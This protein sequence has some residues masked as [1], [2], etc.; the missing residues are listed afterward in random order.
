[1]RCTITV[2]RFCSTIAQQGCK[3]PHPGS[4]QGQSGWGCE[5]LGLE[6]GVPADSRGLELGDIKCLFQSKPFYHSVI[7]NSNTEVLSCEHFD[8]PLLRRNISQ[9]NRKCNFSH[10]RFVI[11]FPPKTC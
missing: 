3:C 7:L 6:G 10:Y 9:A 11:L 4:T 2:R 1:M 8:L 5:Q